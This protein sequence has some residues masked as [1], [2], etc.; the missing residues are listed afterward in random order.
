MLNAPFHTI[1]KQQENLIGQIV[2]LII[3]LFEAR[4]VDINKQIHLYLKYLFIHIF[5]SLIWKAGYSCNA[6]I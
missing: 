4:I 5:N 3:S 1:T 6:A 2:W